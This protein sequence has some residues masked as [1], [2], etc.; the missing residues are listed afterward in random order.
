MTIDDLFSMV[1]ITEIIL[2]IIVSAF[3]VAN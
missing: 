3:L 1:A 2:A